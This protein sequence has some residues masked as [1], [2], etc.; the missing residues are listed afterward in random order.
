MLRGDRAPLAAVSLVLAATAGATT[1]AFAA[2]EAGPPSTVQPTVVV[3]EG[4]LSGAT[5]QDVSIYLGIPYAAPPTGEGRWSDARAA[6]TY[7]GTRDARGFGASCPQPTGGPVD[8]RFAMWTQEYLT[9]SEPGIDEDCLFANVWTPDPVIAKAR[10]RKLPVM[11]FLHGGAYFSGSGSVPVYDGEKLAR[12][13]IVVVTINYRLG[14][15]GF[16]AHPE[17]TAA[18]GGSGNYGIRDQLAALR[19]LQRN[20]GAFGGDPHKITVVGQSAGAGSILALLAAPA[21][22]GLFRAAVI[23]SVPLKGNFNPLAGEEQIGVESLV[24]WNARDIAAARRLPVA[25]LLE[26]QRGRPLRFLP[27]EDGVVVHKGAEQRGI[28]NQVPLMIGYTLNDLFVPSRAVTASA[29]RTE[30]RERYGTEASAFLRFY[31][32]RTDREASDSAQREVT[33]R[34]E[35]GGILHWLETARPTRPVYAYLFS[36]EEPGTAA[37]NFGAFHSSE[38]P[39]EFNTLH[40]SPGRHFT[41]IDHRVAEQF[42]GA[43]VNF[44]RTLSPAGG[45]VP[46]WAPLTRQNKT[47]MEFGDQARASRMMP[48]GAELVL[49]RGRPPG[50]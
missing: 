21:A 31:P 44:V 2:D 18:Q 11:L 29:W 5:R 8:P 24:N 19:W 12:S 9:P 47:I 38:L 35:M 28:V 46:A 26:P 45:P 49:A 1:V 23:Q 3:A 40:L 27:A 25:R 6:V 20:I 48:E 14:A 16:M 33:S 22:R 39:Y 37:G 41:S 42:S 15:L 7:D 36:H 50:P 17:L 34:V 13:G 32:G 4:R 43:L 30:A 10:S